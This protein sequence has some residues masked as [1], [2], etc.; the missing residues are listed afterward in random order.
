ME[1]LDAIKSNQYHA[2][3]ADKYF[4][5]AKNAPGS[6]AW[7]A[8]KGA[9]HWL[10]SKPRL[11]GEPETLFITGTA[12]I[13][14]TTPFGLSD[15]KNVLKMIRSRGTRMNPLGTPVKTV[16]GVN[17]YKNAE[18]KLQTGEEIAKAAKLAR[19]SQVEQAIKY[20]KQNVGS[21]GVYMDDIKDLEL[22]LRNP[23][24]FRKGMT[25]DDY[26]KSSTPSEAEMRKIPFTTNK[27]GIVTK[28]K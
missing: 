16:N 5:E 21:N 11:F 17:Y 18:G 13:F 15:F 28:I 8:V 20:G 2:Q 6:G 27:W 22:F 14:S 12:P 26:L 7:Q 3:M 25:F 10:R 19:D 23:A 9:Y 4:E 1:L 24:K